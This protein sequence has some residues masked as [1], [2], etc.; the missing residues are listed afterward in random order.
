M[1][2]TDETPKVD[3]FANLYVVGLS[4]A[5][6]KEVV[7]LVRVGEESIPIRLWGNA[8][9]DDGISV[10]QVLWSNEFGK[11]RVKIKK[12]SEVGEIGFDE[13]AVKKSSAGTPVPMPQGNRPPGMPSPQQP[14]AFNRPPTAAPQGNATIPRPGGPQGNQQLPGGG[15]SIPRPGNGNQQFPGNTGAAPTQSRQRIRVINNK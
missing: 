15:V 5:E 2:K 7:T 13:N 3:P 8:E 11:S 12:G 1:E 9:G 4:R 10:Q 6:G 14:A